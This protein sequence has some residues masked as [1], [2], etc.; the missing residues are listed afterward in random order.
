MRKVFTLGNELPDPGIQRSGRKSLTSKVERSERVVVG[1]IKPPVHKIKTKEERGREAWQYIHTTNDEP[2]KALA[3]FE[4]MI[5]CGDYKA[6]Y[7][8]IKD[9]F[10]PDFTDADSFWR[11]G[12]FVHNLVNEKLITVGDKTKR[13]I[14][15]EE[16]KQLWTKPIQTVLTDKNGETVFSSVTS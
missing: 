14:S 13:V 9:Q 12:W 4:S 5:P 15:L 1:P 16:A 7:K 11:W 2:K 3:K 6:G 10:P 8:A